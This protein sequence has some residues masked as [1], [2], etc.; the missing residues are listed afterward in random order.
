MRILI[1][2]H[3]P[4]AKFE[5]TN[6]DL[7]TNTSDIYDFVNL[8]KSDKQE[9]KQ[10]LLSIFGIVNANLHPATFAPFTTL[11]LHFSSFELRDSYMA[12]EMTDEQKNTWT[13][14]SSKLK[15]FFDERDATSQPK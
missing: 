3:A 13:S 1:S 4:V 5:I 15:E 12:G 14:I 11:V 8:L 7:A 10:G 9:L 2:P 6:Y